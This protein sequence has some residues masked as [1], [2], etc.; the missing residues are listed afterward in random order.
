MTSFALHD[1]AIIIP[2]RNEA[3]RIG[4]CIAALGPQLAGRA[5]LI[6]VVNNSTDDTARIAGDTRF[7]VKVIDCQL[8]GD[9][10]VGSARK[11]GA[12]HALSHMPAL[13]YILTSDA[14]S[15]VAGDWMERTI[16]YLQTADVICGLPI[17]LDDN[18]AALS[19]MNAEYGTLEGTYRDLVLR[20]VDRHAPDHCNPMPH[21]GEASGASLAF[22]K[23]AYCR[24]GGFAE[25]RTGEDRDIV[26]RAKTAGLKV[27]HASDVI[28]RVSCRLDGRAPGGMA[29]ALQQR[30]VGR[31]YTIDEGLPPAE[32]LTVNQMAL[33]AWPFDGTGWAPLRVDELAAHIE[34]L[35]QAMSRPATGPMPAPKRKEAAPPVAPPSPGAL[36]IWPPKAPIS[37][38]P[39]LNDVTKEY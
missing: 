38:D 1:T 22:R 33:P 14:D 10:G 21:H 13:R 36:P 16:R 29:E 3:D 31:P 15:I 17:P 30:T 20:Y 11:I 5:R 25:M 19:G 27:R 4:D 39:S 12:D 32:W 35:T 34:T 28:V 37:P 7:A 8:A 6:V 23:S 9:G 18:P 2:A 24:I 26:R